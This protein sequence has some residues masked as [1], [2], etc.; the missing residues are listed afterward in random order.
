M[1]SVVMFESEQGMKTPL[2]SVCSKSMLTVLGE[3]FTQ[4]RISNC[5]FSSISIFPLGF[6]RFHRIP[7]YQDTAKE[8]QRC[9]RNRDIESLSGERSVNGLLNALFKAMAHLPQS[10]S[11][12]MQPSVARESFR[13]PSQPMT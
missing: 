7:R 13:E 11:Y 2:K 4:Y 3:G 1:T 10:L 12:Y 6:W 5:Q 9:R 8:A